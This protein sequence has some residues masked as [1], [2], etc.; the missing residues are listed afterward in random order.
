[1]IQTRTVPAGTQ[2][3]YGGAYAAPFDMR[4][5]TISAGYAD[6]LP[7]VLSHHGAAWFGDIRLPIVGRISMDSLMLDIS[8]LPDGMPDGRFVELIGPH[9]SLDAIAADAGTISYEI[10]TALGRRFYREYVGLE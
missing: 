1:V 6:G 9:Q 3:G 10:L 7:R 5:A 4:L 2:I 8:A